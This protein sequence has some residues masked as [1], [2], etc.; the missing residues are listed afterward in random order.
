MSDVGWKMV[1]WLVKTIA[2]DEV[3]DTGRKVINWL[4]VV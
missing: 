3:G 1:Y 2:K 4:I